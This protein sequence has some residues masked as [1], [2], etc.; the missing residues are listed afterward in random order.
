MNTRPRGL[1]IFGPVR[2][3]S[4]GELK[5][6]G[7]IQVAPLFEKLAAGHFNAKE[8]NRSSNMNLQFKDKLNSFF[9]IPEKDLWK[10]FKEK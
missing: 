1:E 10:I 5:N 6:L 7:E 8:E 9:L 4:P 2:N 3:E